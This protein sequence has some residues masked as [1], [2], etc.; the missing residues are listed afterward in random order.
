MSLCIL[1]MLDR[2]PVMVGATLLGSA[3]VMKRRNLGEGGQLTKAMP[4]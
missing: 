1:G 3:R 2:L 4:R